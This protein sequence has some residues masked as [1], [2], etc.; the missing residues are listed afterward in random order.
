MGSS[1]PQACV[2][3]QN[4]EIAIVMQ[5]RDI[6]TECHRPDQATTQ[7]PDRLPRLA[8]RAVEVGGGFIAR[9][10]AYG[11]VLAAGQ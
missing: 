5:D 11:Q 10:S 3:T 2:S 6:G 1:R 8:A 4:V 7:C 9:K